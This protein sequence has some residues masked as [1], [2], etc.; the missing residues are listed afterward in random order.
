MTWNCRSAPP[1]SVTT[2]ETPA[3]A[4]SLLRTSVSA[5][6]RRQW[7]VTVGRDREEQDLAHDGRD[8]RQDRPFDLWRKG[9]AHKREFLG[10]DLTRKEDVSTPVEL[11]PYDGNA[12]GSRGADA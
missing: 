7:I 12:D 6:M 4:S 8:G 11:D 9:P 1:I 3:T 2:S 10:D 5:A